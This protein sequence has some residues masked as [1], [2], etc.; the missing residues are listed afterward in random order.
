M[1]ASAKEKKT[2]RPLERENNILNGFRN[3]FGGGSHFSAA[4]SYNYNQDKC[5]L[6]WRNTNA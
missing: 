3:Y 5:L 4:N 1:R 6:A 2:G